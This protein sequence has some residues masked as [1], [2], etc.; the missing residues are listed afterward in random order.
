L[1]PPT[2]EE[3]RRFA[4]ATRLADAARACAGIDAS[5]VEKL[6][7][8]SPA[9]VAR[10]HGWAAVTALSA[11]CEATFAGGFATRALLKK[12]KTP[13]VPNG[14]GTASGFAKH[15]SA[16]TPQKKIGPLE[17]F[18][19][20]ISRSLA[21]SPEADSVED[22]PR[23]ALRLAAA[24]SPEKETDSAPVRG[25]SPPPRRSNS[26][27]MRAAAEARARL[28]ARNS[29]QRVFDVDVARTAKQAGGVVGS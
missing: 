8:A 27:A 22:A 18:P 7:F 21:R 19:K 14:S 29:W 6:R 15:N 1:A 2:A 12:Q 3:S 5:I 28:A 20:T 10:G 9:A 16:R 13:N 25:S 4:L 26:R 11:L 23:G 24:V 17:V